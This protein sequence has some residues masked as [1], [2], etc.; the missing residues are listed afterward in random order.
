MWIYGSDMDGE[1]MKNVILQL[2]MAFVGS[3]GFAMLFRLRRNERAIIETA[4]A[5]GWVKPQ[6]PAVR[7]GKNIA[8]VGS[9]PSGLAAAALAAVYA[10][11]LAARKRAPVPLF[12]IPSVV[13]LIPGS[14]LYYTMSAAVQGNTE[15]VSHYGSL[16][17]QYALSIAGGICI[18]WTLLSIFRR[19]YVLQ[20]Q[21]TAN[22]V[23]SDK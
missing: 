8:V 6:P 22:E 15:E 13:P 11:L 12:L 2:V 5:Q 19:Y 21:V 10:E 7:T 1:S 23:N 20:T 3:L 16:T 14:T 9:G 4:Y 17:L 18:V